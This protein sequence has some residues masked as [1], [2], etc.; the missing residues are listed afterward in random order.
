MVD[1]PMYTAL[2]FVLG[3]LSWM[4]HVMIFGSRQVCRAWYVEV[5]SVAAVIHLSLEFGVALTSKQ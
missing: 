4:K 3:R 5:G 2:S 1:L